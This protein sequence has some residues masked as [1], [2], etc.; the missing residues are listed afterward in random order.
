M[1]NI[2]YMFSHL[3]KRK[4]PKRLNKLIFQLSNAKADT[5]YALLKETVHECQVEIGVHF[6]RVH[7][8]SGT[9]PKLKAEP[10]DFKD[11]GLPITAT[12]SEIQKKYKKSTL[13][14]HPDRHRKS[15]KATQ[16]QAEEMF[17]KLT[18]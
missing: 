5:R 1:G 12:W 7:K 16:E 4:D 14:C 13:I 18:A 15:D 3:M 2:C 17:Q 9:K 10:Q 8:P 6:D 11:L